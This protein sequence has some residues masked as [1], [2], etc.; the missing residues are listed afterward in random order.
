MLG[1]AL[2]RCARLQTPARKLPGFG[3]KAAEAFEQSEPASSASSALQLQQ[4]Y[5]HFASA[6]VHIFDRHGPSLGTEVSIH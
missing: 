2:L 6:R 4:G 1:C 5:A 3:G